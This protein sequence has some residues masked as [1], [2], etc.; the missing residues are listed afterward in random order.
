MADLTVNDDIFSSPGAIEYF[1]R[2]DSRIMIGLRVALEMLGIPVPEYAKRKPPGRPP[3]RAVVS[4]FNADHRNQGTP[5]PVAVSVA[6][7]PLGERRLGAAVAKAQ[8]RA[9]KRKADLFN[10]TFNG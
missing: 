6:H 2:A 8:A 1:S 9:D 10:D 4:A 3:A 5:R 7:D